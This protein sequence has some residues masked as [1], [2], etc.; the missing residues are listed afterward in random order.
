MCIKE[1][2]NH[3]GIVVK[4]DTSCGCC[5]IFGLQSDFFFL[6]RHK[7]SPSKLKPRMYLPSFSPITTKYGA[8]LLW[9][10]DVIR[11]EIFSSCYMIA[12]VTTQNSLKHF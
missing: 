8:E 11:S 1:L 6:Q 10:F 9:I 2:E 3:H 12:H 5:D 4:F 7:I